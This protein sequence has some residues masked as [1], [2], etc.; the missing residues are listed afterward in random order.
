MAGEADCVTWIASNGIA[1]AVAAADTKLV[2][3]MDDH[4]VSEVEDTQ[5]LP[6]YILGMMQ[7]YESFIKRHYQTRKKKR[8]KVIKVDSR[9]Y[10]IPSDGLGS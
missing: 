1:F 10:R 3:L 8:S 5:G 9:T 6:P 7:A 4:C 2:K